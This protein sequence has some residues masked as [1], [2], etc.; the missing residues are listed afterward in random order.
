MSCEA[1]HHL[2]WCIFLRVR[3][4]G[5]CSSLAKVPSQIAFSSKEFALSNSVIVLFVSV[6]VSV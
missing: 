1:V 6:V 3:H 4:A 2:R 5:S